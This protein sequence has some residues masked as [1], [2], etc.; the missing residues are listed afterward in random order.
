VVLRC[1]CVEPCG[2][3]AYRPPPTLRSSM[4]AKGKTNDRRPR[5]LG[6]G[7]AAT[8]SEPF[9][10]FLE[11]YRQRFDAHLDRRLQAAQRRF[12]RIGTP[13][14]ETTQAL[15]D[16]CKRGGKRV[17]PGLVL[18]GAL[19]ITDAPPSKVLFDAAVA[20]ELLHGYFLVH[21]DWMDGDLTRRGGPSVHAALRQRYGNDHRGD[22][23]AILAG[24]WGVAVATD[25]M[26]SLALPGA[27]LRAALRCFADMQLAAVVGQ[28][29]DLVADDDDAELT[30]RLKTASYTVCGPLLLG[31]ILAG[32][33]AAQQKDI[34]GFA[35]PIGEAFQLRDDLIGVFATPEQTGKPFASDVRAGK[36]TVLV[37]E[38]LRRVS[39]Q[40]ASFMQRTLHSPAP[41]ER[42]LQ[43]FVHLLESSG[44][45]EFVEGRI[46][47]LSRR[48]LARLAKARLRAEG[49]TLLASAAAA[50][51]VRKA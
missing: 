18:G 17:R 15:I 4:T 49:K 33:S 32:G 11:R 23:A 12:P 28:I 25:W 20:L 51:T 7:S 9:L 14:M 40:Q 3:T 29:R 35:L 37:R 39:G 26:T 10:R 47:T 2:L 46:D 44:A 30:Y 24:D 13:S 1:R 38:C 31:A 22:A 41:S 19:C 16:L 34:L 8:A 50:L 42:D 36:R 45:S 5:P 27:R 21:D 43:R 6:R 48:G